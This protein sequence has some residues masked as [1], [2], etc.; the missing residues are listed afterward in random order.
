MPREFE[1]K[2]DLNLQ[3][4]SIQSFIK[5]LNSRLNLDK[6]KLNSRVVSA[7]YEISGEEKLILI[8]SVEH[9][10]RFND[11]VGLF[12]YLYDG[13]NGFYREV[14]GIQTAKRAD[15]V[16]VDEAEWLSEY[17]PIQIGIF[18]DLASSATPVSMKEFVKR[19]GK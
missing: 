13:T 7:A 19:T 18:T 17:T 1:A 11:L 12:F 3:I 16:G 4:S 5:V 9:T 15:K 8:S 10:D 2:K 6:V 14:V